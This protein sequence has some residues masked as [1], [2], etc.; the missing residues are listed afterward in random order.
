MTPSILLLL[1]ILGI[2]LVFFSFEWIS[3][4][5]TALGVLLTLILFELVPP[6]DAFSGF[7]SD[8]VML[9]LGLLIAPLTLGLGIL[10]VRRVPRNLMGW[11]LIAMAYGISA[12]AIRLD[13]LLNSD[14]LALIRSHSISL[15]WSA[16]MLIFLYSPP[17]C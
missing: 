1:I 3:P 16:Y 14:M 2:A 10:C 5:V 8:T 7:G 13:L 9:I 15:F 11:M 17:G 6:D 12:Q 4:D